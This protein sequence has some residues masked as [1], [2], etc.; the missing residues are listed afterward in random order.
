MP[1]TTIAKLKVYVIRL[2]RLPIGMGSFVVQVSGEACSLGGLAGNAQRSPLPSLPT[3][4]VT[5]KYVGAAN[6]K[7]HIYL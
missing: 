4:A 1:S 6:N 3:S 7:Y 5:S 2:H